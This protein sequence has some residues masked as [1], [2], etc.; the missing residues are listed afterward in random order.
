[1]LKQ[2]VR[3][4]KAG[5]E[6]ERDTPFTPTPAPQPAQLVGMSLQGCHT[7]AQEV[8]DRAN[9]RLAAIESEIARLTLEAENTRIVIGA[10]ELAV[11]AMK[12][13][14]PVMPDWDEAP[15]AE[16]LEAELAATTFADLEEIGVQNASAA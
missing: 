4:L 5:D 13:K 11:S 12:H 14:P 7:A 6:A 10:F 8:L 3:N 2:L 1:M 16:A 15:M 9:R